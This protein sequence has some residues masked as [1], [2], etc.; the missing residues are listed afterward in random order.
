MGT[1]ISQEPVLGAVLSGRSLFLLCPLK[2]L[3]GTVLFLGPG[4]G[5][6]C[7]CTC[8]GLSVASAV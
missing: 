3:K 7:V 4:G 5:E 6:I 1:G 8:V 2:M